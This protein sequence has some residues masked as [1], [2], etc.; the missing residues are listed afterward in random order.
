MRPKDKSQATEAPRTKIQDAGKIPNR[1][2]I[3]IGSRCVQQTITFLVLQSIF[4]GVRWRGSALGLECI[5]CF[6][7]VIA[8]GCGD[9]EIARQSSAEYQF[10]H[11]CFVAQSLGW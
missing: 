8:H 7:I 3:P 10:R 11:I 4:A 9:R 6:E 1:P 5:P 2:L